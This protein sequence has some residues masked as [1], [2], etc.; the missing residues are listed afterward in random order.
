MSGTM[1]AINAY[2]VVDDVEDAEG[3]KLQ[4][5]PASRFFRMFTTRLPVLN[6]INA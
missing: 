1:A 3:T 6:V 2:T 4:A 5:T